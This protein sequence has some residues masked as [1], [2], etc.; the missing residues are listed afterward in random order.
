ME[1][2]AI[3]ELSEAYG[4]AV[5]RRDG[6]HWASLWAAESEW[7]LPGL[8]TVVGRDAIVKLW[9]EAMGGY[10]LVIMIATPGAISI[11][12]DRATGRIYTS[13]AAL[14]KGLAIQRVRGQYDDEYVKLDGRWL[15]R[16]RSFRVLH[17]A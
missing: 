15:F 7:T 10:D 14:P 1:R 3:R 4:D 8:P 12:G 6:Q 16:K 2:L 17:V 13:E 5:T 9:H 11:D